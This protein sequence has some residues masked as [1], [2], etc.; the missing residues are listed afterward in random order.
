MSD[1]DLS[2]EQLVSRY[3]ARKDWSAG[4]LTGP[5]PPGGN[6]DIWERWIQ[7][8]PERAWPVFLELVRRRPTDDDVLEQLWYRLRLLL[9]THG[10]A[11]EARV[12]DLVAS[13]DR[14]R[15]I[16]PSRELKAA[17]HRPRPL[18]IP[19]LVKAYLHNHDHFEGAHELDVLIREDPETALSLALEI[20]ERGPQ[21]EFT[22]FDTF[23]PLHELLRQRGERVIDQLER[24][25]N[26]SVL[27]RRCLWRM[28]RHRSSPPGPYD[29]PEPVWERLLAATADTTDYS[30]EDPPGAPN[31]LL[32]EHERIVSSWFEYQETFWAW[33][34][35]HDLVDNDPDVGW[36]V[37]LLAIEKA[38][39]DGALE[40]IGAG[41][42]EDLLSKHGP[43]FIDR[44]EARARIDGPFRQALSAMW[45]SE[46]SDELWTRI[47]QLVE[48]QDGW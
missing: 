45:Q 7:Y 23:S 18:D 47:Q 36:R 44:V 46:M 5:R 30:S 13:N 40:A 11:F 15:R 19:S 27:V 42:L 48:P 4:R 14:L 22:S 33:Q 9:E 3:L 2:A 17:F 39:D 1:E 21:Y 28:R 29:V 31:A 34:R 26:D 25:A 32:P 6:I 38:E 8:D 12:G 37:L 24:A 20:I 10:R 41:P 35:V 16:A 43:V